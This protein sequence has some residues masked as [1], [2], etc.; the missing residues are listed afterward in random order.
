MVFRAG[1]SLAAHLI[2][3]GIDDVAS[4][5]IPLQAAAFPA[6]AFVPVDAKGVAALGLLGKALLAGGAATAG[7]LA[8]LA[9]A[10]WCRADSPLLS[11]AICD[12]SL[13]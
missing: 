4:V 12:A 13:G 8:L 6:G 7:I 1:V 11:I 10:S 3:F 2:R 5:P 9:L